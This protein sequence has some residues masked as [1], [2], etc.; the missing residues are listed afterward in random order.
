MAMIAIPNRNRGPKEN[1]P[2]KLLQFI[3]PIDRKTSKEIVIE[4]SLEH[5]KNIDY[6]IPTFDI[7]SKN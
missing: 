7:F 3:F 4:G 1:L 2:P 6:Y 5:Q